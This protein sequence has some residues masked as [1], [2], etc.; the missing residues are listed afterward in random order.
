MEEVNKSDERKE[1]IRKKK[2]EAEQKK[3]KLINKNAGGHEG[4]ILQCCNII[5]YLVIAIALFMIIK[6]Y[7]SDDISEI[8]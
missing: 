6:Q 4:G 8:H 2:M 3:Q 5:L 1:K 7:F